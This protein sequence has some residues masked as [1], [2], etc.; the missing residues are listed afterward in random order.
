MSFVTV[1]FAA[2]VANM[3]AV[4]TMLTGFTL[5]T[6]P[7][8]TFLVFPVLPVVVVDLNDMIWRSCSG[9]RHPESRSWPAGKRKC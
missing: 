7:A 3:F 1:T 5:G 9:G 6:F 4:L 8:L 2:L